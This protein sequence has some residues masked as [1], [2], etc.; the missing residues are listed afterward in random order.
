[1]STVTS[2]A[3]GV[4]VCKTLGLSP[5]AVTSVVIEAYPQDVLIVTISVRADEPEILEWAK[6][7][8]LKNP[9]RINLVGV[10]SKEMT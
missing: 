1:M 2:E 4:Q 9:S 8:R 5:D 6:S 3:F 7:E 10:E